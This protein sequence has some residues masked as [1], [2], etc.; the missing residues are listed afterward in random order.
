MDNQITVQS[1]DFI[2]LHYPASSQPKIIVWI[3]WNTAAADLVSYALTISDINR[4]QLHA[5]RDEGIPV[6]FEVSVATDALIFNLPALRAYV[7]SIG[8]GKYQ[9][10]QSVV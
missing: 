2:C 7:T 10:S 8:H 5:K 4:F 3:A 1:G 6:G 9:V